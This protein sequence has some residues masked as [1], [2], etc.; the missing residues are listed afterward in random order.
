MSPCHLVTLSPCHHVTAIAL[1]LVQKG[2]L[3]L[4]FFPSCLLT[5]HLHN[6]TPTYKQQTSLALL[7]C[8]LSSH[9]TLTHTEHSFPS[10][11]NSTSS[12]LP[13]LPLALLPHLR[14]MNT[15]TTVVPGATSHR[16][17]PALANV[18]ASPLV[19]PEKSRPSLFP[20]RG[21]ASCMRATTVMAP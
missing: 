18:L 9:F 11:S 10:W 12:F 20:L 19:V 14:S 2:R 21:L 5:Y 6:R 8:L 1:S 13:L 17:I 16:P 4:Y 3:I 7:S 15:S